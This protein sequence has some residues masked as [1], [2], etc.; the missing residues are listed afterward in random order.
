MSSKRSFWFV[1]LLYVLSPFSF[2]GKEGKSN[3]QQKHNA[4]SDVRINSDEISLFVEFQ[5]IKRK[6]PNSHACLPVSNRLMLATILCLK[7]FGPNRQEEGFEK[8]A[9]ASILEMINKEKDRPFA[10]YMDWLSKE[11][12]LN[13]EVFNPFVRGVRRIDPGQEDCLLRF[14]IEEEMV[15][16]F[17]LDQSNQKNFDTQQLFGENSIFSDEWV[18][19]ILCDNPNFDYRE[20]SKFSP[21]NKRAYYEFNLSDDVLALKIMNRFFVNPLRN[22]VIEPSDDCPLSRITKMLDDVLN[23][24]DSVS[25]GSMKVRFTYP[26]RGSFGKKYQCEYS[27]ELGEDE[28]RRLVTKEGDHA[29]LKS[30]WYE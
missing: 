15:D 2:S 9:L 7:G 25:S 6:F 11:S 30:E 28:F 17:F 10:A 29:E 21:E 20:F 27:F 18:V 4:Q 19:R 13:Y 3:S 22:P 5:D 1:I 16:H 23:D 12:A 14:L 26:L 24:Q 8:K